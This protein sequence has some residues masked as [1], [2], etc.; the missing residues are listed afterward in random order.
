MISRRL[1]PIQKHDALQKIKNIERKV[2][3]LFSTG[4]DLKACLKV[5]DLLSFLFPFS[6][7]SKSGR[8][9]PEVTLF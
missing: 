8:S 5:H 4:G 1:N 2:I 7:A 9:N 3:K 6:D